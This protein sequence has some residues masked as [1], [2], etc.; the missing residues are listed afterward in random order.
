MLKERYSRLYI[1]LCCSNMDKDA[2]EMAKEAKREGIIEKIE[3]V[4]FYLK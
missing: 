1:I 4:Q 3:E 2:I